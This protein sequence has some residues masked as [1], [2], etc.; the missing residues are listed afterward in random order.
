MKSGSNSNN[1]TAQ[2]QSA[3]KME[4]L[5]HGT[6]SPSQID[7]S[8]F[9]R[10][11]PYSGSVVNWVASGYTLQGGSTEDIVEVHKNSDFQQ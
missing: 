4:P 7:W 9:F 5:M 6:N 3:W 11:R 2:L 1:D 8:E 10:I